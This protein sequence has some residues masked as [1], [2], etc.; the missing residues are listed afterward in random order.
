[1][2]VNTNN[3]NG[4]TAFAGDKKVG[5]SLLSGPENKL[6][7]WLIPKIPQKV[8]TYHLTMGTLLWSAVNV[9]T[10]F[11]AR[12]DLA[13]L[14]VVSLMIVLQY[15][16]D[17]LDGELGRQRD[18]GLVKWGFYM[19]HFLDFVFLCSLVF[20]GYMI[21]PAGVA[22]WYFALLVI[23]GSFMVNSFLSFGATMNSKYT[24][25]GSA[26]RRC[27]WCSFLSIRLSL[28]SGQ[29]ILTCSSP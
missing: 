9:A 12:N 7:Q 24:I 23:L 10:A 15:L 26:R 14:W 21:S 8:E 3:T 28:S 16:K 13:M 11:Y 17:L 22:A 2:K 1:M 27:G 29:H 25:T 4:T 18:T 19:D 5:R 6:K 20:V